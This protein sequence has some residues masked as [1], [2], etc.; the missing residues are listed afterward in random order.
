MGWQVMSAEAVRYCLKGNMI[1]I[2]NAEIARSVFVISG[3]GNVLWGVPWGRHFDTISIYGRMFRNE[4]SIY[5]RGTIYQLIST[6][7]FSVL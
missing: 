3:D 4:K 6:N 2:T 1:V 7:I 5:L